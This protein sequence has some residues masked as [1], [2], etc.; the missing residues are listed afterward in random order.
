LVRNISLY[1][2]LGLLLKKIWIILGVAIFVG[3][4]SF[5]WFKYTEVEKYQT[6]ATFI[7]NNAT[8]GENGQPTGTYSMD[9]SAKL[10]STFQKILTSRTV[11]KKVAETTE[12]NYSAGQIG[13]MVQITSDGRTEI[14]T[15]TVTSLI[16]SHAQRIA[17]VMAEIAP[18]EISRLAT[19][20]SIKLLDSADLP[21]GSMETATSQNTFLLTALSIIVVVAIFVIRELLDNTIKSANDIRDNF[22]IPIIGAIPRMIE[23]KK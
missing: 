2:I 17:N 4:V 11:L 5:S 6:S 7:I 9:A 15:L 3:V 16:P 8:I 13:G 21:G 19:A 22:D 14:M 23:K 10:A 12:L 20:G 1:D 18:A